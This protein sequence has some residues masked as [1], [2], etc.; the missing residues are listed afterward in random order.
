M[1][2]ELL[3]FLLWD[4]SSIH[5]LFYD[6]LKPAWETPESR[7]ECLCSDSFDLKLIDWVSV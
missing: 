6:V 5:G 4:L 3:S 2:V 1:F 7:L